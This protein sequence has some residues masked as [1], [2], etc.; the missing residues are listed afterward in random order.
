MKL[1][2]SKLAILILLTVSCVFE[3]KSQHNSKEPDDIKLAKIEY[4]EKIYDFGTVIRGSRGNHLFKFKNVGE[5][6]I[7]LKRVKT[8][9][10]CTNVSWPKQPIEPGE[11]AGIHIEYDTDK[12]GNFYS[13]I[14]IKSNAESSPD[15][16]II[17]GK[18]TLKKK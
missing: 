6:P 9:C 3:L 1:K 13:T 7:L 14:K 11:S 16:L 8:S 18:I 12:L 2:Q 10:G 17:K 15:V 4:E 5:I